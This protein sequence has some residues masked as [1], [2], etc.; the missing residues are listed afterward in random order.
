MVSVIWSRKFCISSLLSKGSHVQHYR[1]DWGLDEG[2][3]ILR[4]D[5]TSI[6]L[7]SQLQVGLGSNLGSNSWDLPPGWLSTRCFCSMSVRIYESNQSSAR[8]TGCMLVV[9]NIGLGYQIGHQG[10]GWRQW[11]SWDQTAGIHLGCGPRRPA[12][13]HSAASQWGTR[14]DEI[15]SCILGSLIIWAWTVLPE[16]V[17][18]LQPGTLLPVRFHFFLPSLP[19]FLWK[20]GTMYRP[21][22]PTRCLHVSGSPD[23]VNVCSSW[24]ASCELGTLW[25][26]HVGF[27]RGVASLDQVL[28][29][30]SLSPPL[31][32]IQLWEAD[33]TRY[34][35]FINEDRSIYRGSKVT[36]Q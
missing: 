7:G 4:T 35:Y 10:K 17:P 3:P 19:C 20:A 32:L 8:P 9:N 15:G 24:R 18:S 2:W 29:H 33:I 16:M 25:A 22:P 14:V 5:K 31:I 11:P 6:W 1:Q 27:T 30:H 36:C 34:S 28:W 13:I 26:G 21:Q 12:G 23:T